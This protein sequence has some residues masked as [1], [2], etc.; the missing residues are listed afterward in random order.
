MSDNWLDSEIDARVCTYLWMRISE[1][2]GY[3]AKKTKIREALI[4]GPLANRSHGSIEYRFQN[5]SA[6]LD[7]LNEHW[8][9]GYKPKKN[10]GSE[11]A[12]AIKKRIH[13]FE[14]DRHARRLNWLVNAIPVAIVK[15]SV[16]ELAAGREFEYTDSTE[17]DEILDEIPL[18]PKMVIGYAALLYFG[19]PLFSENFTSGVGAPCFEKLTAS[20][21][22][23]VEKPSAALT[24]PEDPEFRKTVKIY[25]R[26]GAHVHRWGT[27]RPKSYS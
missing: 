27:R 10:V 12:A 2:R 19:A 3:R 16:S 22:K 26:E 4:G 5:I 7:D 14:K 9:A 25:K 15:R 20:G 21:F 8:I 11:T 1:D 18:T 23:I 24:D 13:K 6:V 17:V